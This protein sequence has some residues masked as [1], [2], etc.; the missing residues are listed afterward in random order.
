VLNR[1]AR[2]MRI[3][4]D[5]GDYEL[6]E[7]L[8]SA[9][10]DQVPMRILGYTIM[11]NHW[12]L[13][14]WPP[15]DTDL[16]NYMQWLTRTHAQAWHAAHASIGT[17]ALYQGRFKAIPVQTDGHFLTVCRYVERNP[18]R[19]GLVGRA[20]EWRWGS[21]WAGPTGTSSPSLTS[22]P[23]DRPADWSEWVEM[24]D[25][26]ATGT[27]R[28]AVVRGRPYGDREWTI[29]TAARLGLPGPPGRRGR[30]EKNTP[31]DRDVPIVP[32]D[33]EGITPAPME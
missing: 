11:P 17:G 32:I 16:S 9:A 15:G 14:L 24:S 2:R 30:P 5:D 22:W 1:A 29:A 13:V 28:A 7:R 4:S 19:A 23:V 26:H 33:R 27:L 6:F 10:L 12:H 25:E 20:S 3:F 18:V 8:L 21:A 31:I